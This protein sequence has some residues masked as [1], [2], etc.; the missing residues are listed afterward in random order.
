[1]VVYMEVE[2]FPWW[3][4]RRFLSGYIAK[5]IKQIKVP[6]AMALLCLLLLYLFYLL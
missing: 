2:E 4:R 3:Y 6:K 5:W 1:M